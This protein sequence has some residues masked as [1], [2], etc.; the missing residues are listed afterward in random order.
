[1]QTLQSII[2]QR[3]LQQINKQKT[4]PLESLYITYS[5]ATKIKLAL[6]DAAQVRKG[7]QSVH[8]QKQQSEALISNS[9]EPVLNVDNNNAAN[10]LKNE[11]HK[12]SPQKG[13]F[14][15]RNEYGNK[16]QSEN[17]ISHSSVAPNKY[18]KNQSSFGEGGKKIRAEDIW[19][20]RKDYDQKVRQFHL[21]KIKE[22][23]RF[24]NNSLQKQQ[25]GQQTAEIQFSDVFKDDLDD[26]L[27]QEY[28]EKYYKKQL[29]LWNKKQKQFDMA[30]DDLFD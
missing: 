10:Q 2:Q 28:N 1:M 27:L 8:L 23:N 30:N 26:D 16:M 5:S 22:Y 14:L 11:E 25:S 13:R 7:I 19:K 20:R 9:K 15:V 12:Q 24:Q 6:E 21:P 3:V 29:F 17:K 4:E 18:H